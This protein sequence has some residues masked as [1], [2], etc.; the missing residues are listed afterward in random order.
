MS[1]E[2]REDL[3]SSHVTRWFE[4]IDIC[5]KMSVERKAI[6]TLIDN[7]SKSWSRL[8]YYEQGEISLRINK[9]YCGA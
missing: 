4:L 6:R 5:E 7:Y 2:I 8:N 1:V 3:V 9:A